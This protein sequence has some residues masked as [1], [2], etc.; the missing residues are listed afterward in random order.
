MQAAALE[1]GF[2]VSA[3]YVDEED[4]IQPTQKP[5]GYGGTAIFCK[6]D[7]GHSFRAV[8]LGNHR[9][10]LATLQLGELRI[11]AVSCYLPCRGSYKDEVYREAA[12]DLACIISSFPEHQFLIMGD[13]NADLLGKDHRAQLFW[14]VLAPSNVKLP[15]T[16]P[17]QITYSH[18][19]GDSRIDFFLTRPAGVDALPA[20]VKVTLSNPIN[21]SHHA[22]ITSEIT[23][24]SSTRGDHALPPSNAPTLPPRFRRNECQDLVYES[25]I[26]ENLPSVPIT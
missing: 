9:Y 26:K 5:R 16:Y 20:T 22:V 25:Y 11:C 12:E 15:D 8:K 18:P 3:R 21:T 24:Q 13:F 6:S 17:P 1:H 19:N 14:D 4:P 10:A 7:L 2:S 23:V